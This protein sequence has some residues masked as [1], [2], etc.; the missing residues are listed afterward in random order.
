MNISDLV[1]IGDLEALCR[2]FTDLTGAPTAVL[3]REGAILIETG[4]QEICA[5]FHRTHPGTAARCLK[6]ETVPGMQPDTKEGYALYRCRNGLVSVS[7][8]ITIRGERI[9][10]FV[11]GQFLLEPP[12]RDFFVRQAE[13][14]GFD[15][16]AYLE[17]LGKVPILSKEYVLK[18]MD[19]FSRLAHLFSDMALTTKNV[20]D[21]NA[22]LQEANERLHY[23]MEERRQVEEKIR[24]AEHR[25]AVLLGAIPD[26]MFVLSRDGEY[27]DFQVPDLQLLA[28]PADEII[29]KTIRDAGFAPEA[30]DAILKAI[31]RALATEELQYIEYQL[32]VPSG[33]RQFEARLLALND[34]EVLCIVRD[35][36]ERKQAERIR[37]Q[38][39]EQIERNIEQI[40]VLAD[41]IRQPLQVILGMADLSGEERVMETIHD[42]VT[43]INDC[44]KE[45]DRGWIESRKIRTFLQRHELL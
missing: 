39:F 44:I 41:H 29:G 32:A 17:A 2:S 31:E 5:R 4:W 38:A 19:F 33:L 21:T 36:T 10:Y 42:Q 40:A 15:T 35:I 7:V 18:M 3:D 8:P 9:G 45:L 12:D 37:I 27:R 30:V 24:E 34:R 16:D 14:F 23:E 25:N 11:T 1:D 43:R 28:L 26:M 20:R 22:A 13:E 6:S